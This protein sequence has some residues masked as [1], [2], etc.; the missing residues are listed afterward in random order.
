MA[1]FGAAVAVLDL[2]DPHVDF[3]RI[4]QQYQTQTSFHQADVTDPASVEEAVA[5]IAD[6]HGVVDICVACAG[7][8]VEESFLTTTPATLQKMLRVNVEGVFYTNQAC[9]KQMITQKL[10]GSIVNIA[11]IAALKLCGRS[12]RRQRIQQQRVRLS[13]IQ[14][15]WRRSWLL[16]TFE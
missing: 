16:S 12:Q 14:G 2:G 10:G 4:A 5:R 11:S 1:E 15:R 3:E 7:V 8:A 6:T 13:P 9:A